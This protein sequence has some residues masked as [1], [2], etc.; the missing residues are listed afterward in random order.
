VAALLLN[1]NP[2]LSPGDIQA[3]LTGTAV[4]IGAAGHDDLTGGGRLDAL[5]AIDAISALCPG[6]CS[7]GDPCTD[8]VCGTGGCTHSPLRCDDA[9]ACTVD[10]CDSRRGCVSQP[11]PGAV[12]IDCLVA[13]ALDDPQC[14]GVSLPRQVR[15]QIDR[16]ARVVE[17]IVTTTL[18]PRAMDR[19][20]SRARRRYREAT[21]LL[22]R[23][24]RRHLVSAGCGTTVAK[25]LDDARKRLSRRA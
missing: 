12:G 5:A 4:D 14:S 7:D 17:R 23:A 11:P 19:A 21:R 24:V 10:A 9:I 15:K 22:R 20:V 13:L 18:P 2:A 25:A 8:D 6:G 16:G 1:K 3:V